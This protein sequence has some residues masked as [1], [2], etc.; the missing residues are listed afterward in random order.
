MRREGRACCVLRDWVRRPFHVFTASRT[1]Q[2]SRLTFQFHASRFTFLSQ[3]IYRKLQSH[4]GLNEQAIDTDGPIAAS[5]GGPAEVRRASGLCLSSAGLCLGRA[6]GLSSPVWQQPQARPVSRDESW[7]L[8]DGS[9]RRALWRNPSD[10]RLDEDRCPH[11][12]TTAGTSEK[13]SGR[14]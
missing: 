9:D 13:A 14:I 11:R 8:W 2:D 10:A 4:C 3:T 5:R 6:S 1:F 12:Q 7:P